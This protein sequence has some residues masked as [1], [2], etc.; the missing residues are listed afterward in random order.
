MKKKK[1]E[2]K[3]KEWYEKFRWFFTSSGKLV[4]GGKNAE[5]N[6]KIINEMLEDNDVVLHTKARGS[7]FCVIKV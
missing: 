3:K 7:P 2:E 6:E 5:Q 1:K 4:I